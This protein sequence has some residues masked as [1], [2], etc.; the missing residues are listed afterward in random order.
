M[1]QCRVLYH[2]L[3]ILLLAASTDNMTDNPFDNGIVTKLRTETE[4][5][6]EERRRENRMGKGG[7]RLVE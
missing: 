5:G 2:S 4:D 6:E 1:N 7:S 3:C